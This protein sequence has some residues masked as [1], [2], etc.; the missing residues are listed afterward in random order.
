M[1]VR[2]L[3]DDDDV[4]SFVDLNRV[5]VFLLKNTMVCR[6][7]HRL[8]KQ[9]GIGGSAWQDCGVHLCCCCCAIIQEGAELG[10]ERVRR[11][12]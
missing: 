3:R 2:S 1:I 8:R 4:S 9:L 5:C 11:T 12:Y 10:H 6:C 7:I